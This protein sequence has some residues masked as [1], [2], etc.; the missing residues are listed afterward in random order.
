MSVVAGVFCIVFAIIDLLAGLVFGYWT[1][2]PIGLLVLYIV[3]WFAVVSYIGLGFAFLKIQLVF[4][5]VLW[6]QML[7]CYIFFS[8]KLHR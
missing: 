5:V 4:A 2:N 8:L 6:A 3:Q 1:K 7:F